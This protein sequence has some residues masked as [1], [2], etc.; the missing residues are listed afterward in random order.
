M[1]GRFFSKCLP[2]G[3]RVLAIVAAIVGVRAAGQVKEPP[4][5]VQIE[6]VL[7]VGHR[8]T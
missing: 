1:D 2:D 3:V 7:G 8:A 4:D 6:D 5:P